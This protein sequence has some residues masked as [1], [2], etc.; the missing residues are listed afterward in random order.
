MS[1]DIRKCKLYKKI[2]L[3]QPSNL[4]HEEKLLDEDFGG[5]FSSEKN[6]SSKKNH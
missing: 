5:N 4:N 3:H 1:S 6:Y 2:Q